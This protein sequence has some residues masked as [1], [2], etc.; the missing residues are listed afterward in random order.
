MISFSVEQIFIFTLS[1]FIRLLI[2]NWKL[3]ADVVIHS[4]TKYLGGHSDV[5]LG[6]VTCSSKTKQGINLSTKLR[7]IQSAIGAVSSPMDAWLT[8]RGLRTLHIRLER[9]CGS[10]MTLAVF[11]QDLQ[12]KSPYKNIQITNVHYPG[13]KSHPQ[14]IL[15]QH[16]MKSSFFGGMLSIEVGG[17][18][19][20]SLNDT[21]RAMAFAGAL[22][23]IKRATS[24]GGTESLIEHRASI[25]P[26]TRVVSPQGLLRVSVG[27]ENVLD[28]QHDIEHAFGI[29]DKVLSQMESK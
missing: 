16:Q 3:G 18:P 8:L 29:A 17:P 21:D 1:Y 27:L 9:Q 10:A 28:L 25:E 7:T 22:K 6:A 2:W 23:L 20:S 19:S 12:C 13:L 11:L 26:E 4:G 15:A 14:H 24:L 5:L